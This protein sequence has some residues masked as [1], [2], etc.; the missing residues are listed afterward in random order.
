LERISYRQAA[1]LAGLP[2][3]E[4]ISG[5][6]IR[7]FYGD[8]PPHLGSSPALEEAFVQQLVQVLDPM[9]N[10]FFHGSVEEG[11]YRWDED[12]LPV[13][14]LEQGISAE[15]VTVYKRDGALPT[16]MFAADHAWCLYQGEWV[17]WSVIGCSAEMAQKF[18]QHSYLEA[19]PL[20]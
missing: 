5:E 18:L 1:L 4:P 19:L 2:E 17:E 16:Y 7:K 6:A 8:W 9:T 13:D 14:W 15:L 3:Q 10:T 12:E 20:V 11:N